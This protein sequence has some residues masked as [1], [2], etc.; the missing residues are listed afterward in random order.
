MS[1]RKRMILYGGIAF[2]AVIAFVAALP[3]FSE[4]SHVSKYAPYGERFDTGS[5]VLISLVLACMAVVPAGVV[6]GLY[7]AVVVALVDKDSGTA[8]A[9][10][11]VPRRSTARNAMD[12]DAPPF[13]METP[14]PPPP[15][16]RRT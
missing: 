7:I 5:T 2:V 12:D 6:F 16:R 15:S 14:P 10:A 4:A 3:F 13:I 11:P 8:P 9:P 1:T